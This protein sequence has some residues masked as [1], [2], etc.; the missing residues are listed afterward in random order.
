MTRADT[1][2]TLIAAALALLA[3]G[4]M[5]APALGAAIWRFC[6]G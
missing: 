6:D 4:L 3:F 5:F 2:F 1:A